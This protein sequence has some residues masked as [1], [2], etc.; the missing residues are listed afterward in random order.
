MATAII[1]A[2]GAG[3]R[4]G[5]DIPKQFINIYDK[6]AETMIPQMQAHKSAQA[7]VLRRRRKEKEYPL[8]I[9]STAFHI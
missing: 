3:S 6:Q 8:F 1:I 7:A 4:M 5:Q 9:K 2:G